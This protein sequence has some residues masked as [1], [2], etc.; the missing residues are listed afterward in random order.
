[1]EA[2]LSQAL[3][4]LCPMHLRLDAAG[5]IRHAGP[6]LRKLNPAGP[7]EGARFLEVFEP[8]RPRHLT[9][10]EALLATAG[11]KLRLRLRRPSRTQMSG[12]LM[13]LGQGGALVNLGFGISIVE[14][15]RDHTLT[16]ADFAPTDLAVEM[17]FLIEAKSTA[18][19]ALRQMSERFHGARVVAERQ[20]LTDPVTGLGNRRALELVLGNLI[21]G[22]QEF[23]LMHLDLD[24][25]KQVND[26]LGHAAGDHVLAE[27][28]RVLS[29]ELREEDTVARVGGDEFVLIF[30]RLCD[31][32][33]L[34]DIACRL[35]RRLEAPMRWQGRTCRISASAGIT[36]STD[37]AQPDPAAMIADADTALY[38]SKRAGR[39]RH[40][41]YR[42]TAR[43]SPT[44]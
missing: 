22:R 20:A 7:L 9:G 35:I 4:L 31:P 19:E 37:Y 23:A 41:F 42:D 8:L 5:H 17:L 15:V 30:H 3:D 24:R 16:N 26:S 28:A 38:A 21:A 14:A 44:P 13:P 12:V 2:K 29:E 36:L 33:R 1:M 27:V 11:T 10:M 32:P 6:T 43:A 34:A 40:L 18:M 39:G 25:F